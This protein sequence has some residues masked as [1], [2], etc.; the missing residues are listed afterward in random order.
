MA[1]KSIDRE[2]FKTLSKPRI[3]PWMLGMVSD[4]S[5]LI[6]SM[7]AIYYVPNPITILFFL[8]VL[9]NR[10]HGLA[11]LGH[12]G[13]HGRISQN[14][15]LND[16]LSNIFCFWP[17][18]LTASGYR[19]LHNKHHTNTGTDHD[20]ELAHK[21][22]RSPQWDLPAKP[23]KIIKYALSDIVGMSIPDY[24]I[25]I[26]YSKADKKSDYIPLV[27]WHVIFVTAFMFIDLWWVPIAWYV[28]L[29]SSFMMFF[30]LR[31]WLEH[32]GTSDT[33]R[34]H[35][36]F[37]EGAVLAPH[38]IWYHWEHHKFACIPYHQLPKVR[39]LLTDVP[40]MRLRDLLD[41]FSKS[42]SSKSGQV[43][44]G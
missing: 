12:E 27:L 26:T 42:P 38:N 19:S 5:I 2:T 40:V 37:W 8:I 24:W 1:S 29:V 30:R 13:T 44:Q 6:L 10:Q 34:L 32:Q 33:H 43:L 28:A 36:T 20:P 3:F 11:I 23:L 39:S 18:G 4:W 41:F 35:L 22:S 15:Q 14:R 16:F 17:L 9:G 31:L 21:R 25:I 7:G